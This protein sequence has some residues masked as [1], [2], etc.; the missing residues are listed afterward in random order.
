M[1]YTTRFPYP[2]AD[3]LDPHGIWWED[4]CKQPRRRLTDADGQLSENRE[5]VKSR[6]AWTGGAERE[7]V[8]A[9][10]GTDACWKSKFYGAFVLNRRVDS[11]TPSTRRL[12]DGVAMPVPHRSTRARTA[13]V[14]AEKCLAWRLSGAPD[15]LV[16]FHTGCREC[17]EVRRGGEKE[18]TVQ[19]AA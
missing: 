13:A 14:I 3:K 18:E 1:T 17:A 11:S 4:V 15:T 2:F 9:G 10:N 12:L 19:G 7:V 8:F 16:D 6:R 5:D